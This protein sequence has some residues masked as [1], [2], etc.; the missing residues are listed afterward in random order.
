MR[1][2]FPWTWGAGPIVIIPDSTVGLISIIGSEGVSAASAMDQS[3]GSISQI[4]ISSGLLSIL[5]DNGSGASS[6]MTAV[7]KGSESQI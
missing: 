5:S 7:G 6:A 4:T 3:S 2:Y 1:W